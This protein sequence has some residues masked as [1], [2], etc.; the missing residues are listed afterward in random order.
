MVRGCLLLIF[1]TACSSTPPAFNSAG[2]MEHG[3]DQPC[4]INGQN[5]AGWHKCQVVSGSQLREP[6]YAPQR[7]CPDGYACSSDDFVP[8]GQDYCRWRT[9]E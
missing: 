4:H 8:N 2:D 5:V 9:T 3:H 1:L 6:D 7:C